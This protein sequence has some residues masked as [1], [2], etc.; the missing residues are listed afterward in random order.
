MTSYVLG[1]KISIFDKSIA[2]ILNHDGSGK[3]C[4]DM[5]TK[6]TKLDEIAAVIF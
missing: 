2:K 3:R 4:F 6:R 5:P 1:H